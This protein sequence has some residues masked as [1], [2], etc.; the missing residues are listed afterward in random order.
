MTS[1]FSAAKATPGFDPADGGRLRLSFNG[2]D[3]LVPA[4]ALNLV[5]DG[6]PVFGWQNPK[7]TGGRGLDITGAVTGDVEATLSISQVADRDA[8]EF[9]LTLRNTGKA[10]AR[11]STADA[12]A[13]TLAAGTWQGLSFT[14]KWGGEF[15]PEHFG[16]D[17]PREI[18]IRSGRSSLGQSPWLGAT[19]ELGAVVVAPV[20]SGNWHI[21]IAP[22]AD[23]VRLNAGLSPWKFWHDLQP[24]KS[25][26]AP[27]VLVAVGA[28]LEAAAVA[29]TRAVGARL[30]R[31]AASE[32]IPL[33]WNH[34]W[35][36]EDKDITEA[37]F[38]ENAEIATELGF[39]VSTLDAG[40]FGAADA[41]TFWWDIRG[42]F[43]D[44]NLAR[45][46]H[47]ISGLAD[48]VR[49]RGQRFG[50]WME[51]EAVGLKA[52]VRTERADI[53]ARRDDDPPEAPLD[54]EDPGFLGYVCLGS[55]A[56][57]AH[58]RQLL[59]TLVQKT[60]CEWIKIDF[61]LDPKAGCSCIDH[62]HGAGDGLYAHYR[63]LYAL[64]DEFRAAH[65]EV[66]VE[67]CASGGLRVDAGLLRHVH[68]AFLSDPDWV[69]HHLVTVHGNSYLLPPAAMLHW[70]MSEWRGKN[71]HQTLSLRDP[72]LTED[73]FDTII[74]GAFMHRF[75]LSW[76][77]PDLPQKWRERL[78]A[79]LRIYARDVV[80][81]V[82]NGDMYR[83]TPPPSREGG[84][85][86]QPRFQ[87]THG[88]R[89]LLLGFSLGPHAE[90]LG[91]R[92]ADGGY[93]IRP[94]NLEPSRR[95]RLQEL[96]PEG[97]VPSLVRTGSE[98]M[99]QGL[100]TI[101]TSSYAGILAPA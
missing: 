74:R 37:I 45:F 38:L 29:L 55:E 25:F 22:G 28:D 47:G 52:R 34:W 23:G 56:G 96:S 90:N 12:F 40:W 21:G 15:E 10:P 42:D 71:P 78:K 44:E 2:R 50:I 81:F 61:N 26:E 84:G 59:E 53:M 8:F 35:P 92:P 75:G 27:S 62:D 1:Q 11:I 54:A 64:Y 60:R 101:V 77:L 85:E 9:A 66:I 43:S 79:H 3:L 39:E 97:E 83:L 18:E 51:V 82:R 94:R 67:A 70:P 69:P 88:D 32:A 98:W 76:R 13:G 57:R 80:P 48:A 68:C 20:W 91:I 31:S 86:A 87:L 46:P 5:I 63:G 99:A 89:H 73:M 4:P 33:E 24:G 93:T 14:S 6:R 16:L 100:P 30:P 65:P 19:G 58:A 41:D 7:L 49:Q 95:Y 17:A 36:Y 72:A